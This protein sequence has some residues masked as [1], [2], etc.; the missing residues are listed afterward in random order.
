MA[1]SARPDLDELQ[2]PALEDEKLR[3]E[4]R[5]L[6]RGSDENWWAGRETIPIGAAL[7][8]LLS[9]VLTFWHQTRELGRQRKADRDQADERAREFGHQQDADRQEQAAE[10]RRRYDEL[11]ATVSGNLASDAEGLRLAAAASIEVAFLADAASEEGREGTTYRT[12]VF[13]LLVNV[14]SLEREKARVSD[15]VLAGVLV[16]GLTSQLPSRHERVGEPQPGTL[17]LDGVF[18]QGVDLSGRG[19]SCERTLARGDIRPPWELR[20]PGLREHVARAPLA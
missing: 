10:R 2:R 16:K 20:R 5:A 6:W 3:E 11:F 12:Q 18:L 4:I 13:G 9:V 17:S 14:L 1:G 7:V 15:R 8:A 19:G